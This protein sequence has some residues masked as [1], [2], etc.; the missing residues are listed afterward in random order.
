MIVIGYE[1]GIYPQ[2]IPEEKN[3]NIWIHQ[4]KIMTK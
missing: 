2:N 3:K 1:N 4:N